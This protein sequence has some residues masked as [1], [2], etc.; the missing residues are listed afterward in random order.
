MNTTEFTKPNPSAP[1]LIVLGAITGLLSGLFGIG[2]GVVLVPMLVLFLGFQQRLAAGTSVAAI[3]PAAIIGGISYG[4]QGN[5]DW[6]AA[7]LLAVGIVIGAQVGSYLLSRVPTGFLRWLFMI[8]LLGVVVSLWFVVP[9]RDAQ[10]DIDLL[11]GALLVVLGLVTGILSGLLGVGGGVVVVP[12]LMFFF[13]ASDLIAKGTSLIMLIPGSISGT[14]GNV[15]R[16]NVDLRSALFL[17]VT[18]G[19]LS[20]L[21]SLIAVYISPFWSNIAF[22]ILLA[23]VLGQMVFKALRAKK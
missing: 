20:P 7:V 16:G 5:V 2:G 23:Y 13:G 12:A 4:V 10:I 22:S 6:L 3:L 8:F 11:T 9:Q 18:A 21:G 1:L 14:L 15:K 19:V 17:G